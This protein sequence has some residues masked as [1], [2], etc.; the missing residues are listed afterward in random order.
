MS[1]AGFDPKAMPRMFRAMQ[2]MASLQ[3]N[4]APEFLLTHPVT[5]ARIGDSQAR[6]DKLKTAT[7][8][9]LATLSYSLVRLVHCWR[10]T[11]AN[12][13]RG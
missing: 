11:F 5:E 13:S 10:S 2:R 3:G 12:R 6:A 4:D 9:P 7:P 8:N 1:R